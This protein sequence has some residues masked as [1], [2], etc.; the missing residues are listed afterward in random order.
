MTQPFLLVCIPIPSPAQ[1]LAS[2]VGIEPTFIGLE[3]IVLPLDERDIK[4]VELRRFELL[5][6]CLQSICA[7]VAP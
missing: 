1:K 3:S 4:L 7:T 6:L 5:T 2:R